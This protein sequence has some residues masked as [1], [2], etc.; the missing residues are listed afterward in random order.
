MAVHVVCVRDRERQPRERGRVIER[1]IRAAD[2][3]VR[4]GQVMM[5]RE[6]IGSLCQ[7]TLVEPERRAAGVHPMRIVR[8]ILRA[9]DQQ[10][11][12]HVSR[13]TADGGRQLL[14]VRVR[15][16]GIR[17]GAARPQLQRPQIDAHT[18]ARAEGFLQG[19]CAGRRRP[20]TVPVAELR[21]RIAQTNVGERDTI[22][23]AERLVERARSFYPDERIR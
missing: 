3:L 7:R 13:I 8:R 10:Q 1:A 12:L 16:A 6:V 22:V 2:V 9:S 5:R 4:V 23:G 19:L 21:E 14:P 17:P 15:G 20:G 18:V 11:Q